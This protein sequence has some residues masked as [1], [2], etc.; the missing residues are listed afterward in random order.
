MANMDSWTI[1][2]LVI[3]GY[4]AVMALVRLMMRRRNQ[5]FDRFQ[6][7]VEAENERKAQAKKQSE[8]QGKKEEKQAVGRRR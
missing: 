1:V 2:L 7:E 3:A 4:V 8:K 5:L 6:K